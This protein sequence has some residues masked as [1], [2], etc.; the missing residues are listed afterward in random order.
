M[1][2]KPGYNFCTRQGL[3]GIQDDTASWGGEAEIWS[4]L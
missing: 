2:Q 3:A 1:S 4:G